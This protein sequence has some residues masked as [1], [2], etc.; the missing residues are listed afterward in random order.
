M[1]TRMS[2]LEELSQGF[3]RAKSKSFDFDSV[4]ELKIDEKQR[5]RNENKTLREGLTEA[6][7]TDEARLNEIKS[8]Q[9]AV[10]QK[11]VKINELNEQNQQLWQQL[12]DIS[13][14]NDKE[15][16]MDQSRV[17]AD[18]KIELEQKDKDIE[19]LKSV[20]SS[21]I[22]TKQ[23]L[24]DTSWT[25]RVKELELKNIKSDMRENYE[26][27]LNELQI[28]LNDRDLKIQSMRNE[29]NACI[30]RENDHILRV[31]CYF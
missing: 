18:L 23:V 13:L 14:G 15:V 4:K 19:R 7:Q 31:K 6:K 5:L 2:S 27:R 1:L 28:R 24:K 21:F 20:E 22:Q 29:N 11:Q 25:L 10:D 12:G 3:S 8:L 30:E 16:L 17:I 26:K 9:E